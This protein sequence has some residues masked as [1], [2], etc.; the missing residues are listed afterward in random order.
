MCINIC[1]YNVLKND[2]RQCNITFNNFVIKIKAME[3]NY[4][5]TYI[6]I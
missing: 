5:T 4:N 3:V 2:N 1:K 6:C